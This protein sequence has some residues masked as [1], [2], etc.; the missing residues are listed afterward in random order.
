MDLG[1]RE[2]TG[3]PCLLQRFKGDVETDLVPIFEDV[4]EGLRHTV[5]PHDPA[6]DGVSLD[7][8][9]ER[10]S[11]KAHDMQGRVGKR[12]ASGPPV[13]GYPHPVR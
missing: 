10:W 11:A 6:F 2:T 1:H 4:G 9:G 12:G 3:L 7:T 5:D 13:Y 8:F